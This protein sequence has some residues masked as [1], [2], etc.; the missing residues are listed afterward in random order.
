MNL[1]R[2][3]PLAIVASNTDT[4]MKYI[5]EHYFHYRA[6]EN[7]QILDMGRHRFNKSDKLKSAGD[8]L[9]WLNT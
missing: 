4:S 2:G 7:T 6:D 8:E 3:V 5:E 9:N 1:R